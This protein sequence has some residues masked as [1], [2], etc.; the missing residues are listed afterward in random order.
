MKT[1]SVRQP[2]AWLIVA[3]F[4]LIENRTWSTTYRGPL[5]IHASQMLEADQIDRIEAK[6]GIVIDRSALHRGGIV[7]RVTL[8]DVVTSSSSPWFTGPFGWVLT[9]PRVLRFTPCRGERGL[10]DTPEI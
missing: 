7:G 3:G 1:L 8:F 5:L 6:F 2:Y 4:K 10:F 9:S